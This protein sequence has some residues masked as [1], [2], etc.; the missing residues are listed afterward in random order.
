[1][2][3]SRPRGYSPAGADAPTGGG[4]AVQPGG[5]S[6]ASAEWAS[7]ACVPRA[8]PRLHANQ[9]QQLE[10]LLALGGA[11]MRAQTALEL[12]R[13]RERALEQLASVAGQVQRV[14]A[15]VARV[16]PSFE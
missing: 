11:Q 5:C 1:M 14:P 3:F 16:V 15:P 2:A 6:S 9:H 10:Q 8:T 12:G 13:N 4:P 7:A